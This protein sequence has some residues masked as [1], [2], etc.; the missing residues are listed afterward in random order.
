MLPL[1]ALEEHFLLPMIRALTKPDPYAHFPQPLISKLMSLD[2][3]RLKDME[4]G[5]ISLQILSHAPVTVSNSDTHCAN[6]ELRDAVKKHPTRFA[7]FAMLNMADA[8]EAASE[9]QYCVHELGFLGTLIPN[10][11][12]GEFYDDKKFWPVFEMA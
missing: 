8:K 6:Q 5:H 3:E 12:N 1:I 11:L 2:D 7:G 9:L 4:T 10:H